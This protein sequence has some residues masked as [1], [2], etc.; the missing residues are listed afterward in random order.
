MDD[1]Y[2]HIEL[3]S[4]ERALLTAVAE[5]KIKSFEYEVVRIQEE[6]GRP[7]EGGDIVDWDGND[8]GLLKITVEAFNKIRESR[9]LEVARE[10]Q[11]KEG[12]TGLSEK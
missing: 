3:T 5:S 1:G 11:E 4:K 10:L 8:I 6:T 7:W 12:E 9:R 2:I